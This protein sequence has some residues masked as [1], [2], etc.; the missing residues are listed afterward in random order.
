MSSISGDV[1][2]NEWIAQ[3]KAWYSKLTKLQRSREKENLQFSEKLISTKLNL[4]ALEEQR[5]E[6]KEKRKHG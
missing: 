3:Y 4:I 1:I 5:E 6:Q 2:S